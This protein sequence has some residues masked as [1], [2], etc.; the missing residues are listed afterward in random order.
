MEL[1]SASLHPS[2]TKFVAGG[3]DFYVH[4]YDFTTGEELDV[5]KGHHGPV[6]CVRFSPDGETFASGYYLFFLSFFLIIS[7]VLLL[8]LLVVN[9]VE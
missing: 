1:N 2:N 8:L 4:V 3:V 7:F 5:H 6:H 9:D